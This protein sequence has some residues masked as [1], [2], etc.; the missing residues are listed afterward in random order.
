M[1]S[2]TPDATT[3][4]DLAKNVQ[5]TPNGL[6]WTFQTVKDC[7][8][9]LR[10]Y[11]PFLRH[12]GYQ[13]NSERVTIKAIDSNK[14]W[15]LSPMPDE[16]LNTETSP[17]EAFQP[18]DD[19]PDYLLVA[20][21][22]LSLPLVS[23]LIEMQENPGIKAIV[24][25]NTQK[26]VIV[27]TDC[28]QIP[29][30]ESLEE[31]LNYSRSQYWLSS[32]LDEFLARCKQDLRQDGSNSIEF[33]YLTYDPTTGDDWIKITGRYRIIDAGR[34]GFYQIGENINF[35]SIPTPVFTQ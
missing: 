16:T 22:R 6:L 34:L 2:K 12:W 23:A 31:C 14:E 13:C 33:T 29:I 18:I 25:W 27:T 21:Q 35:Q 26:Q 24:K 8:H 15:N 4:Q 32:D 3:L 9:Y 30:G 10:Q 20:E 5:F 17:L 28:S 19:N 1:K 11:E 7:R